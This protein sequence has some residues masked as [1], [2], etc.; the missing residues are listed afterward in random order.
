[1]GLEFTLTSS[2]AKR[3][4]PEEQHSCRHARHR[5]HPFCSAAHRPPPPPRFPAVWRERGPCGTA[6]LH[7]GRCSGRRSRRTSSG[8][9]GP[10]WGR[11]ARRTFRRPACS[12]PCCPLHL[13]TRAT[14][15]DDSFRSWGG[16]TVRSLGE[17]WRCGERQW[18]QEQIGRSRVR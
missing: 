5:R 6:W 1:M 9:R 10:A 18:G 13:T 11:S 17:S 15:H 2:T 12:V 3:D 14:R 7:T 4:W 8:G 16:E